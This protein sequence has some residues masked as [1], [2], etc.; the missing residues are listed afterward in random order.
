MKKLTLL[1]CMLALALSAQTQITPVQGTQLTVGTPVTFCWPGLNYGFTTDAVSFSAYGFG[2]TDEGYFY[3]GVGSNCTT[4]T[5]AVA[6]QLYVQALL[7][8]SGSPYYFYA[9]YP[10]AA[11]V[12]SDGSLTGGAAIVPT[13][14][15][16]DYGSEV[17]NL[18]TAGTASQSST[19][20]LIYQCA[21][22]GRGGAAAAVDGNTD[23]NFPDGSTTSTDYDLY[24]WWQ[25]DLGSPSTVQSIDIYP[26]TSCGGCASWLS[27]YW[28][29]ISNTPFQA[30]D[31]PSNL[32][33]RPGTWSIHETTM[34]D[35][36]A[37]IQVGAYTGQYVRVQLSGQNYLQIAEVQVMAQVTG[38]SSANQISN[39]PAIVSRYKTVRT[40]GGLVKIPRGDLMD[41]GKLNYE[42]SGSGPFTYRYSFDNSQVAQVKL[43]VV[44]DH[45]SFVLT[46]S[47]KGWQKIGNSLFAVKD[48]EYSK[49]AAY[50]VTS[51]KAPGLLPI[52]L[53]SDV[54]GLTAAYNGGTGKVGLPRG[55][56]RDNQALIDA[57]NILDNS[58]RRYVIGPV[59][60]QDATRD[61][62]IAQVKV[63]AT[64]Y[65]FTFLKPLADGGSLNDVVP[66][67]S[68]EQDIVACLARVLN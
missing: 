7:T 2:Y 63:W 21:A 42:F 20:C 35:P 49:T 12:T 40:A 50:T 58:L 3:S 25:V 27:D 43:G 60:A 59:F 57:A 4:V 15:P 44:G 10:V 68:L 26:R 65:G 18:A 33:S 22:Y 36:S 47:P 41:I 16:D 13:P 9:Q 64:D 30:S 67:T 51:Q 34:P 11:A 1:L 19:F 24:A 28:V 62:V 38:S 29:F 52:F 48:P 23:G 14:G 17:V 5:P 8:A 55:N 32:V 66:N 61:D 56:S 54:F 39:P 6:G 37:A 46:D 45:P 53:Q 31:T